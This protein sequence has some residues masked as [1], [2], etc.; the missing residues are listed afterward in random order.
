MLDR[1][2]CGTHVVKDDEQLVDGAGK[3]QDIALR[4]STR[5]KKDSMWKG[6]EYTTLSFKYFIAS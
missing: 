2:V 4:R 1:L 5:A 6:P 3:V